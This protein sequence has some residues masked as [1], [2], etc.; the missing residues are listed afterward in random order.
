MNNLNDFVMFYLPMCVEDSSPSIPSFI[1]PSIF[2]I[3]YNENPSACTKNELKIALKSIDSLF[4][5]RATRS[6]FVVSNV[7]D[8][9]QQCC[10]HDCNEC[11]EHLLITGKTE[12][13]NEEWKNKGSIYYT[14]KTRSKTTREQSKLISF[15]F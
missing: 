1:L 12:A 14:N 6:P 4:M 10:S 5:C 8:A 15:Q 3:T 9:K 7:C 2:F 11:T 13:F